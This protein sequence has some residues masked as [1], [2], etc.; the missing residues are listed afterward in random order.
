M[1]KPLTIKTKKTTDVRATVPVG[2]VTNEPK[3]PSVRLNLN[4]APTL[5]DTWK[6]EGV[7]RRMTMTDMIEAAMSDYLNKKV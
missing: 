1:A 3:E 2:E 5:R 7:K 4:I 6:M